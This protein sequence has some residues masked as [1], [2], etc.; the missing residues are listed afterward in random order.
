MAELPAF[1]QALQRSAAFAHPVQSV[2]VVET[3]ISWVLLTGDYA[4]KIK[5]PVNFGFLDFSTLEQRAFYCQEELRL[6]QRLAPDVYLDVVPIT[7]PA[8]QAQVGGRGPVLDYAVRMKQFPR[9][10]EL[11][12]RLARGEVTREHV[13]QIAVRLAEFHAAAAPANADSAYGT[14]AAVLD[15]VAENFAQIRPLL[16]SEAERVCLRQVQ[17]WARDFGQTHAGLF[18]DRRQRGHVRECHGDLHA[19]NIVLWNDRPILFDCIEFNPSLRWIDVIS[20]AAFLV[21]DLLLRG[22]SDLA[23]L[24]INRY[25]QHTGDYDGIRLLRFYMSYRAM[26]RCKVETL[27][28]AQAAA[29][30]AEARATAQRY[31][32]FAAGLIAAPARALLITHGLSGSGKSTA[33]RALIAAVPAIW[34]RSDV[35]RKRLFGFEPGAR[36]GSGI[37]SGV[38]TADASQRTYGRLL[39]LARSVLDAGYTVLVDAAFLKHA[40][41]LPFA[42]LAAEL[43]VP[44]LILDCVAP[45]EVLR[46]RIAAR[47]AARNDPSE[48]D[49]AVLSHQLDTQDPLTP[50]ERDQAIT[51]ADT[52]VSSAVAALAPVLAPTAPAAPH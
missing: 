18:A 28:A 36:T 25:L 6:N 13:E 32:H 39:E 1:I 43:R 44:F 52:D 15:P 16:H 50:A 24:F 34:L 27:R 11:D 12:H 35:E 48:A 45:L 38:Y 10:S 5:K 20:D 51:L 8:D 41:R 40:Q 29:V 26:V 37:D 22:H 7:G 9:D 21:M 47:S 14:P 46:Q 31:L 42:S 3:H 19:G 49:L 17:D 23:W 4:Y 33:A 30:A 2:T